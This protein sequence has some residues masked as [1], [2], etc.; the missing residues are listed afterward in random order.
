MVTYSYKHVFVCPSYT[1]FITSLETKV[2][3]EQ[4]LSHVSNIF[5]HMFRITKDPGEALQGKSPITRRHGT[6]FK[7]WVAISGKAN[8]TG[9]WASG[10]ITRR[11][12][13][14][15]LGLGTFIRKT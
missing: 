5:S 14:E 4:C 1:C 9:K 11:G 8:S 10:Q 12:R 7:T 3:H 6:R 2:I 15:V 13:P